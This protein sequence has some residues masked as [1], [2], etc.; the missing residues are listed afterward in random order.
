MGESLKKALRVVFN[1]SLKLEFHGAKVTSDGGAD[2]TIVVAA[3][4]GAR[5]TAKARRNVVMS[6]GPREGSVRTG[7][8]G[9]RNTKI[10]LMMAVGHRWRRG[11]LAEAANW[12]QNPRILMWTG[13]SRHGVAVIWEIPGKS[14]PAR[15]SGLRRSTTCPRTCAISR[16]I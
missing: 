15:P 5:M 2:S 14:R 8:S 6:L 12:W 10:R 3:S 1:R 13:A 7:P 4:V 11:S 16:S 9:P